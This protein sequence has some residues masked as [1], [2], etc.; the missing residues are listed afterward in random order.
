MPSNRPTF[1]ATPLE[2]RSWL[3]DNHESA[4]ELW[5]GFYKKTSG[6]ASIT[7]PE[8]VDE[9][10][11]FGWIDGIRKSLGPDS[12]VI[13]FTPRK[14]GSTWSKVNVARAEALARSGRMQPAGA[15]AFAA[16]NAK[17]SGI[18]SFEQ[19][20]SPKLRPAELMQFR[21]NERAWRF[22]QSQPPGYRKTALWWV[23]SAKRPETRARR[24]GILIDDSGAGRRIALLRRTG[25]SSPNA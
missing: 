13:R 3:L 7:W 12:Y 6:R 24:L 15:R 25:P 20:E 9:A 4:S 11:C 14:P 18:Y 23:V 10:L 19:R 8:S 1:F 21:A 2:F 16:R 22:F 17:K 5:V